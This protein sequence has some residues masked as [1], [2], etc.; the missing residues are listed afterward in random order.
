MNNIRKNKKFKEVECENCKTVVKYNEDKKMKRGHTLHLT[1]PICEKSINVWR[2]YIKNIKEFAIDKFVN[3]EKHIL[4]KSDF[5][6]IQYFDDRLQSDLFNYYI[7]LKDRY[8]NTPNSFVH[9]IEAQIG[10]ADRY[11]RICKLDIYRFDMIDHFVSQNNAKI[12]NLKEKIFKLEKEDIEKLFADIYD[13]EEN[14]NLEKLNLRN[15]P[16]RDMRNLVDGGVFGLED[17]AE[18]KEDILKIQQQ[19]R[20]LTNRLSRGNF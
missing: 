15:L 6:Y 2:E 1:C 20:W 4:Y 10:N 11:N 9:N 8:G 18:N 12:N 17:R 14:E 16:I 13:S 5:I 7:V 19:L 3:A